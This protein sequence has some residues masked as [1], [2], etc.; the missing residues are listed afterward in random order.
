[1]Q[2]TGRIISGIARESF[3]GSAGDKS[4][5]ASLSAISEVG[6]KMFLVSKRDAAVLRPY[7][8]KS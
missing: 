8:K 1:V 5:P 6:R 3:S 7:K 4:F 2:L